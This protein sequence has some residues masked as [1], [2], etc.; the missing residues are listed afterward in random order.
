MKTS[1]FCIL[2]G[3]FFL[4]TIGWSQGTGVKSKKGTTAAAFLEIGANPR[5]VAM[6][7]S[8]VAV[9]NDA[10]SMFWNPSGLALM[11]HSEGLFSHTQWIAGIDLNY[12]AV[13]I[14]LGSSGTVGASFYVMNSGEMEVTTEDRPEGNGES[15]R[16]QDLMLGISYARKL[17]DRFAIG[18]TF[19]YIHSSLWQLN[20]SAIAFD[21]GLQYMTPLPGLNLGLSISNFGDKMAYSGTNLAVPYDSDPKVGGNND[22]VTAYLLTGEWTLPLIFRFGVAYTL[23]INKNQSFIITAD[24]LYPNNNFNYMNVGAEFSFLERFFVRGGFQGLFMP[25]REGGLNLG[26]GVFFNPVEVDYSYSDMGQLQSVHRISLG[27]KF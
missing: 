6:G 5:A 14:N 18:G 10:S 20:S 22:H 1:F 24:V 11:Q 27:V 8:Y 17:T 4:T 23:E 19:K 26:G 7:E 21:G 2:L 16:V 15:F 12:A 13:A 9:C 3:L 25:D